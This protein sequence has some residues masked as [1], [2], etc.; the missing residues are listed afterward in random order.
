[1]LTETIIIDLYPKA[2]AFVTSRI[3]SPNHP[4]LDVGMGPGGF[5]RRLLSTIPESNR[6][7][8]I[9]GCDQDPNLIEMAKRGLAGFN[10]PKLD[11]ASCTKL[12]YEDRAFETLACMSV[13][14][15]LSEEELDRAVSELSR[16]L[17]NEGK[18]FVSVINRM[19]LCI[20]GVFRRLHGFLEYSPTDCTTEEW[21]TFQSFDSPVRST[22][23]PHSDHHYIATFGRH[24]F[25][26]EHFEKLPHR[27]LKHDAVSIFHLRKN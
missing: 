23:H 8:N 6:G 19:H 13:L 26:I 25:N 14:Q 7:S 4:F 16:V 20:V 17:K 3:D 22:E 18:A 1:M 27:P 5:F 12:P 11:V 21:Q 15:W 9:V 24:G 10:N 2:Q